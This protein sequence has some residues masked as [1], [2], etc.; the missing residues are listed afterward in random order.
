MTTQAD[1][2]IDL[3]VRDAAAV[4]ERRDEI[5]AAVR[6][7]AER[8]AYQLARLQ[9]G[10]YGRETLSTPGGEWT[11]KHEAGELEFLLFS[12]KSGSDTYV[13]STK[14][15]PEPAALSTALDDYA[16]FVTAWNEHVD[17]LSGVL[18]GVSA[19]FPEPATTEGVVAERDRVLDEI[20]DTCAVIAGEIHRYEGDDYGTFTARVKGDR[21][22]LKHDEGA[23]SYLR[24]GGSGGL[25]L[26][27]QYGAPS[28]ADVREYADR[29]RGFVE[30]YNEFVDELES[31]LERISV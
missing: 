19:E 21:W 4:A 7:H 2:G 25:Y 3:D 17:S 29:F 24:I 28:A 22:E 15:P 8:I 26:L 23:V 12:P 11:V 1:L 6:D 18:D 10:D 20:R 13:I 27:S 31:D 9:G 5:V 14:Q 16:A 30:T